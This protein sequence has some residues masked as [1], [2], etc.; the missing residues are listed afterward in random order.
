MRNSTK[1]WP[2]ILYAT[3]SGIIAISLAVVLSRINEPETLLVI[4]IQAIQFIFT[5]SGTFFASKVVVNKQMQ[6]LSQQRAKL[7]IRRVKNIAVGLNKTKSHISNQRE[8]LKNHGN[9]VMVDQVDNI[10]NSIHDIVDMNLQTTDD[11]FEDWAEVAPDEMERL[12]R[13]TIEERSDKNV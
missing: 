2:S 12:K 8:F 4:L 3:I 13:N 1:E 6:E 11:M 7:A 10:L 5:A 9:E